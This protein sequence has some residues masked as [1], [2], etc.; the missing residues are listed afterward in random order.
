MSQPRLVSQLYWT[1]Y[2]AHQWSFT[3]WGFTL[4]P[5]QDTHY[6]LG[7]FREHYG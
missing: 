6:R 3:H 2:Y 4:P 5:F 7:L 1:W